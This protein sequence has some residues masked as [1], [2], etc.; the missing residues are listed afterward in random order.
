MKTFRDRGGNIGK[1]EFE[2]G[3]YILRYIV[4]RRLHKAKRAKN[5]TDI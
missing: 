2:N 3:S 4:Y 5:Y 1:K